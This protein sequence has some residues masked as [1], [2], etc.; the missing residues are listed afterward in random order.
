MDSNEAL[1][2]RRGFNE[3]DRTF[4]HGRLLLN[5]VAISIFCGGCMTAPNPNQASSS[6]GNSASQGTVP[7]GKSVIYVLQRHSPDFPNAG[8]VVRL[9]N[10][11]VRLLG[12]RTYDMEVLEP[13]QHKLGIRTAET[14]YHGA[15]CAGPRGVILGKEISFDLKPNQAYFFETTLRTHSRIRLGWNVPDTRFTTFIKFDEMEETPARK[16]LK[17]FRRSES[18]PPGP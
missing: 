2:T 13:G 16:L 3:V 9:D 11:E 8:M 18:L 4:V 7:T 1:M 15:V 10:K 17:G 6:D 14:Y 12:S 5:L